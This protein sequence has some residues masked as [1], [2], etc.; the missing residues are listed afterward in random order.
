VI[1]AKIRPEGS[2]PF[3]S[4]H[5]L[6]FAKKRPINIPI[7]DGPVNIFLRINLLFIAFNSAAIRCSSFCAENTGDNLQQFQRCK[8]SIIR[9]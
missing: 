1:P 5:S 3:A 6:A 4:I 8:T 7:I 2:N 9:A